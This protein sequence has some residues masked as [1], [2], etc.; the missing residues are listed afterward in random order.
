MSRNKRRSR[1][2]QYINHKDTVFCMLYQDKHNLLELYNAL[3][4]SNYTNVDELMITTLNGSIYIKYKNDA[5]FV[6]EQNLYMFEQQASKNPNMPLRFLFYVA[7]VLKE[8]CPN[9]LL[10]R[11]TLYK[12]PVP[13]FITFYNGIETME[14]SEKILKLSDA[15]DTHIKQSTQPELE[16]IVRVININNNSHS[17]ILDKCT[18]LREY[19]TFVNKVRFNR[20]TAGMNIETAVTKAVDEC[21]NNNILS[22]F[23]TNN[24]SE[25]IRM[26]VYEYDEEGTIQ[27]IKEEEYGFGLADGQILNLISQTI[28]KVLK[29]KSPEIIADELEED[30]DTVMPIYNAVLAAAPEY[31]KN[32]I[33]TDIKRSK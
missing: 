1:N 11:Q 7:D 29:N 27:V 16:L 10:H 5:S 31:D 26:S 33:L 21:I 9:K 25:V 13:H 22:D 3:N 18:T 14:E 32:K 2:T 24:R 20:N 28:K 8:L 23:F 15:F 19:M 6:F 17:D 12:I 4:N 30:I